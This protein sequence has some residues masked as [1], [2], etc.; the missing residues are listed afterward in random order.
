MIRRPG[1]VASLFNPGFP[2]RIKQPRSLA[3]SAAGVVDGGM[4]RAPLP[5]LLTV[6]LPAAAARAEEPPEF[7]KDIRPLLERHC[8]E[9]HGP[10]AQE[11]GLRLDV[12]QAALKGGESN[13]PAIVPGSS[14]K[15][16]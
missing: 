2:R 13:E 5:I 15:S 14:E 11:A 12:K 9:C 7:G 16:R 8:F 4:R 6:I 3:R 1:A 10:Q